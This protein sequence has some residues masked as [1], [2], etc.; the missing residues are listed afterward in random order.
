MKTKGIERDAV[1][2]PEKQGH[3]MGFPLVLNLAFVRSSNVGDMS[4]TLKSSVNAEC[5]QVDEHKNFVYSCKVLPN[6]NVFLKPFRSTVVSFLC[7]TCLT[8]SIQTLP[9]SDIPDPT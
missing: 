2:E 6:G 3:W 4:Q 1:K 5:E 9:Q 7:E 8:D